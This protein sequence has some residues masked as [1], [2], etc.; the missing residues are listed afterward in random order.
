MVI[1][2][3]QSASDLIFAF[4]NDKLITD[5]KHPVVAQFT[6]YYDVRNNTIIFDKPITFIHNLLSELVG[7]TKYLFY[8]DEQN[9][10]LIVYLPELENKGL[11]G[12]KNIVKNVRIGGSSVFK[13]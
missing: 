10:S 6:A 1:P 12:N 11:T 13:V 2:I 7:D 8:Y 4:D 9:S 5:K 3:P